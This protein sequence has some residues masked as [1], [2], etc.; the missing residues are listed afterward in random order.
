MPVRSLFKLLP[1]IN[2]NVLWV[3]GIWDDKLVGKTFPETSIPPLAVK[4]PVNV[5]A[6][7]TA[8]VPPTVAL[9]E[10]SNPLTSNF[11]LNVTFSVAVNVVNAP[12][13]A[14]IDPIVV[15]SI[16]PPLISTVVKVD[17]PPELISPMNLVAVIVYPEISPLTSNPIFVC[18]LLSSLL[19][20]NFAKSFA[21]T[22]IPAPSACDAI[23]ALLAARISKSLISSVFEFIVVV[24]PSTCKLP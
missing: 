5:V 11:S 23:V 22:K 7:V 1:L 8:N 3:T 6:P 15:L 9:F 13:E 24:V 14:I 10:T 4:E 20:V 2:E 17:V 18:H 16:A 12:L 21:P 19:N